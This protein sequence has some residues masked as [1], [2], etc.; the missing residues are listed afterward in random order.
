MNNNECLWFI[1]ERIKL[2]ITKHVVFE[3]VSALLY[4]V[5]N[6]AYTY[7]GQHSN[8]AWQE[9]NDGPVCCY[10][11]HIRDNTIKIP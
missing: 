4:H 9:H 3:V 6:Y 5:P 7:S 1:F 10:L 2:T 11:H 8:S